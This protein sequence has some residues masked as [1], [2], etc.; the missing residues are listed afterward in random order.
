MIKSAIRHCNRLH[1]TVKC[2]D[3]MDVDVVL[4]P[5]IYELINWQTATK[6]KNGSAHSQ[7]EMLEK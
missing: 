6:Y 5:I 7:M 3:G 2:I 1:T 4:K